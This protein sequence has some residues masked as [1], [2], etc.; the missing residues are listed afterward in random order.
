[1]LPLVVMKVLSGPVI[2]RVGA[3]RVSI[4]CDLGSV[5][6]VGVIPVLYAADLLSLPLFLLMV[7]VAGGLRGPGDAAKSAMI[8]RLVERAKVPME[9]ATGLYS[10][11]ER[12]ASLLGAAFA[13]ALVALVGPAQALVVDALSFLVS[14]AILGLTTRS[15]AGPASPAASAPA[16]AAGPAYLTQLR[17]GWDFLRRDPVLVSLTAMIA[18]TNLLDLAWASVIVPVWALD[19]GLG[20]GLVGATFAVFAAGSIVGSL[21]AAAWGE[22]IPRFRTYLI[23]FLV[24]GL[25]RFLVM[26]FDTPMWLVFTVFVVGGFASGFLNPILGAVFFER[27]PA[28]LVGRVSA[29]STSVCFAL[30]PLGGLLGG[31]L[32]SDLGLSPALLVLGVGYF[33]A[34]MAPAVLPSFREMDRRRSPTASTGAEVEPATTR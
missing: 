3:R 14:A 11:V 25:P 30:M 15:L 8:P 29:L 16:A 18:I 13:G 12:S 9:R 7:A 19:S 1:M 5:V 32:I 20:A 10:S 27:I 26:A 17:E 33:A 21:V 28:H 22:R 34:T 4:T 24:T 6:A 31:L 23:A 2:D